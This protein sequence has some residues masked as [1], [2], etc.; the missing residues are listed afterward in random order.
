MTD[1]KF[2][3]QEF[4]EQRIQIRDHPLLSEIPPDGSSQWLDKMIAE[5][6]AAYIYSTRE[7]RPFIQP[8]GGFSLWQQQYDLTLSLESAGADFIPL[9]IDSHTRQNDYERAKMLLDRSEEYG[10]NLLNGYP[11]LA[12]GATATRELYV[13]VDKPISLRHGTPDAR[14]LVEIAIDSGVT[15]IEGGGLCYCLPYSR[16]YPIDRAL[17]NWRYVDRL[18]AYLSKPDRLIH[19]ESFGALTGTMVPPF[20]VVV[21]EILELLLAAQEGVLS[22]AVSYSQTGSLI[23]DLATARSLRS[24]SEHYLRK[25]GHENVITQLVFYQWMGA[26][27]PERPTA[28]A[29]IIQ[30][31]L[32]SV[33]GGADKLVVKTRSE[34]LGIPDIQSNCD[35]VK[36]CRYAMDLDRHVKGISLDGLEEE[37]EAITNSAKHVLERILDGSSKQLWEKVVIAV[38]EGMIDIPFSPHKENS[39]QL[40]TSRDSSRS[41]RVSDP[42]KVPLPEKFIKRERSCLGNHKFDN[43][44][45]RMLADIMLMVQ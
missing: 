30:G 40:W 4:E 11:L 35:A 31:A 6:F 41:I 5:R 9:T 17:L 15:E 36:M 7:T 33:F 26:F 8:R 14:L 29:L 25:F 18:C 32:T 43:S 16:S 2:N 20:I 45:D 23:Q 19:R 21:V 13:D 3:I 27:P 37:T 22:F 44:L 10:E 38:R 42:G 12:H 1:I 34:A 28:D 39:N 24:C